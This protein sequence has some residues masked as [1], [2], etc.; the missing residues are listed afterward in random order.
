MRGHG[1][2]RVA[3]LAIVLA[4]AL[5]ALGAPWLAGRDPL[6]QNLALR[7]RPPA[8]IDPHSAYPLGSDELGRDLWSRLLFGARTSLLI[9]LASTTLATTLGVVLGMAAG[10]RGGLTDVLLAR[11]SDIQ[12]AIPYLILA[13]AVVAVLGSSPLVLVLVLGLTSWIT[14]F[15]V[16]RAQTL[17]L[18]ESDFVLAARACGATTARILGRH[19]LPNLAA[20]IAVLATVLATNII[21]FEAAL[22]F[23]G[24]GV[25]P[26]A[27][28]WGAL[29]AEGREYLD[30]AWWLSVVPGGAL[31]LFTLGL[32]LLGE[33]D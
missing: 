2:R 20:T 19:I 27:P 22:G 33:G 9:A 10:Y 1:T 25:P 24:L 7:L 15:R 21:V 28:S 8:L 11:W 31:G 6:A 30:S 23:L 18:R 14:F 3:G 29:I 13:V 12:Q 5:A 32:V 17:S 4:F 26:P 16:V